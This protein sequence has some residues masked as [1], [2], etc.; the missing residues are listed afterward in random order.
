VLIVY[1][2]DGDVDFVELSQF[3]LLRKLLISFFFWF[4]W[5]LL[6]GRPA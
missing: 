5:L 4:N 2:I 1:A 6:Y 3:R